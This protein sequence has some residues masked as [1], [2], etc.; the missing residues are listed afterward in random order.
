MAKRGRPPSIEYSE[1]LAYAVYQSMA[2][3]HDV[4]ETCDI[5]GIPRTTFYDWQS[6]YP[7]FKAQC[8]RAREALADYDV[9][10]IREE[11]A[12]TDKDNAVA[13]RVKI[14]ALQWLAEKRAPKQYG[15]KTST[16]VTGKD[17][18]AIEI[19]S[20]VIDASVLDVDQREAVRQALLAALENENE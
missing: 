17:G 15:N 12:M 14:S 9:K 20:K 19:Q 3:G 5:L 13:A 18:G 16:E 10:R 8:A 4:V 6:K 1:E 7:E 11:I 2:D